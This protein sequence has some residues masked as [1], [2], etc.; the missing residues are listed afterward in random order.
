MRF[1]W[2]SLVYGYVLLLIAGLRGLYLV[3]CGIG[4]DCCALWDCGEFWF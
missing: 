4:V 2:Y 1:L 3:L